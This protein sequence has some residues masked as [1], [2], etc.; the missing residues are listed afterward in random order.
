MSNTEMENEEEVQTDNNSMEDDKDGNKKVPYLAL[1]LCFGC[2]LG[3]IYNNIPMF[4]S[5]GIIIGVVMEG[6]NK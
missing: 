5:A 4:V 3:V 2:T 6:L 1:G